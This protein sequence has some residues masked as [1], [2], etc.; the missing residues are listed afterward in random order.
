[1]VADSERRDTE[2]CVKLV[3][4]SRGLRGFISGQSHSHP[5]TQCPGTRGVRVLRI[6]YIHT[7]AKP[8]QLESCARRYDV[9]QSMK[10]HTVYYSATFEMHTPVVCF[11][12]PPS[13]SHLQYG[14]RFARN[15]EPSLSLNERLLAKQ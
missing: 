10:R 8:L 1:M 4:P 9:E 5:P 6:P 15:V 12:F 7:H 13:R 2:I 11:Y 3:M 14:S